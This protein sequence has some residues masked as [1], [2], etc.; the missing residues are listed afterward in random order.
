MREYQQAN[1]YEAEN[2]TM[3]GCKDTSKHTRTWG[4]ED[5]GMQARAYE[6][7]DIRM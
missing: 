4:Y 6:L 2:M 5:A 7:E 1:I 3:W